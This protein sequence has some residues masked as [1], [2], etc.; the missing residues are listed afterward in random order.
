MMMFTR[1][2]DCSTGLLLPKCCTSF[3]LSDEA[4][5]LYS[6]DKD[7]IHDIINDPDNMTLQFLMGELYVI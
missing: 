3:V 4:R 1:S 7:I 5:A 2:F 6:A